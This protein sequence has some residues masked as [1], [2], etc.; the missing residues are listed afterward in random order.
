MS[1]LLIGDSRVKH[2]KSS[3]F[4]TKSFPGAKF[5]FIT[6]HI[7]EHVA[8]NNNTYNLIIVAVG[9]NSVSDKIVFQNVSESRELFK[10]IENDV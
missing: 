7:I 9:I 3:H 1:T 2:I 4:T 8:H 10:V 5:Q 6:K